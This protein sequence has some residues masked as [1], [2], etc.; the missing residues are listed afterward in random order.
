LSYIR[1]NAASLG[2]PEDFFEH[3]D[4][5]IHVPSGAIQKDGPSAGI[6]MLM[7]LISLLLKRPARRDIAMTGE[8][9]LTGRVLPVG[10]IKEKILAARRAQVN[11]IIIPEKNKADLEELSEEVKKGMTIHL[12]DNVNMVPDLVLTNAK[13]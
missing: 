12:V 13:A 6:A 4:I 11:S 9:T 10:G 2:I 7:A 8:M 3:H 5:H 1:S